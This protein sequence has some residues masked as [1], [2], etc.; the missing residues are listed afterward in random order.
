MKKTEALIGE[1][2]LSSSLWAF[3]RVQEQKEDREEKH[4]T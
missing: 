3:A 1:G 4:A 2:G